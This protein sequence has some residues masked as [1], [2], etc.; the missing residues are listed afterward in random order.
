MPLTKLF[1]EVMSGQGKRG[2]AKRKK[3]T[4]GTLNNKVN[5]RNNVE[6]NTSGASE[7][8]N[9]ELVP[10][11]DTPVNSPAAKKVNTG[12]P[13]LSLYDLQMTILKAVN[14]RAD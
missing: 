8:S 4:P 13:E 5:K 9:A 1:Q 10:L 11:P 14:E 2:N 6:M 7:I 12:G 3:L